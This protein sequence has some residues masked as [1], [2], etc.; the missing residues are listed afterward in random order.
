M[1][2]KLEKVSIV[3]AST[4]REDVEKRFYA[5]TVAI[6]LSI[7]LLCS[8]ALVRIVH[9]GRLHPKNILVPL[10]V[11]IDHIRER[12]YFIAKLFRHF[13]QGF[14]SSMSQNRLQDSSMESY[15]SHL[16]NG[17]RDYLKT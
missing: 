3:F 2:V 4:L 13:T 6:N 14:Q 8:V 17:K 5:G 7:R 9:M 16:P 15:I 11:R 1:I 10:K 12:A